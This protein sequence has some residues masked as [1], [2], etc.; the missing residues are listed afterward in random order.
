METL[1]KDI[2]L[3]FNLDAKGDLSIVEDVNAVNQGLRILVE[4][5]LGFRPGPGNE[6]FGLS[7]RQY[8]FSPLSYTVAERLGQEILEQVGR[9]EP[10]INI[11]SVNVDISEEQRAYLIE[12]IY[13][14][15]N[16]G[17]TGAFRMVV[18]IQ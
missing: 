4:T 2:D 18:S 3:N 14:L 8:I 7:L 11:E 10:R 1:Y 16:V 5:F 17:K 9:Y 15:K 6:N 12:L 13:S